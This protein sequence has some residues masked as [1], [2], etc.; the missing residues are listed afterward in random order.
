VYGYPNVTLDKQISENGSNS[1]EHIMAERLFS[2]SV[3]ASL[4]EGN[5]VKILRDAE[6][7]YPAWLDAITKATHYVHFENYIFCN[8]NVGQQF[9]SL[10]AER[11]KAGVKIR[12]LLDW[13]GSRFK[14]SRAM[15]TTL[16]E[17]GVELRFFNPPKLDSPL[18]WMSRN[19]RKSIIVDG[20]IGY[21]SGL[22]IGCMW[23]GNPARNLA[24]WRDTG[25]EIQGPAIVGLD[26]AFR[27][28]WA[29][30][31]SPLDDIAS[32][33]MSSVGNV[34]LRVIGSMPN[35][36]GLYRFDQMVASLAK[37]TLWLTDAYFVGTNAYV[38]TLCNAARNGVDVRLLVPGSSDI[39]VIRSLSR[40][41]YRPLLEAGIR[42]FE[43]N[44]PML[45]AKTAVA[46][47]RW[48][49]IGSSN[50]NLASWIGNWELDVAIEDENV[51][52]GLEDMYIDDLSNSTEIVLKSDGTKVRPITPLHYKVARKGNPGRLAA[53][54]VGMGN[55]IGAVISN[56]RLITSAESEIMM[57]AGIFMLVF[58]I[59]A[60]EWPRIITWPLAIISI[61]IA[62]VLLFRAW[63]LR[64][65]K[66]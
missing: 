61:W 42:V 26:N 57:T 54:A 3:N 11:A 62:L 66:E 36:M 45:H 35:G 24:A 40:S 21:V 1:S 58:A 28:T 14:I 6:E 4:I 20:Q 2:R 50:L 7:N 37:H 64:M 16:R 33:P 56:R 10:L 31:G 18:G 47:G 63:R 43:W 17:S 48:A 15:I 44:G 19:H 49:R 34:A 29:Q 60:I 5:S 59:V 38:R 12:L 65:D 13:L 32:T 41:G 25:I 52:S 8:D 53:S 23:E 46:D 9:V 55:T 22:C 30:A 39:P 51:A 27:Q